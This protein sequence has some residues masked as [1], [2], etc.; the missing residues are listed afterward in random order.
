MA[1]TIIH[2][3]SSVAGKIPATTDLEYGELAINTSDAKVFLKDASNNIKAINSWAGIHDKPTGLTDAATAATPSTLVL[4]DSFGNFSAST[5]TADL[6]GN[7][8]GNAGTATKLETSRL[9]AGKTFDG[10]QDVTL[11]TLTRGTYLTGSNFNGS[12]ATTWAVDAT[13][14]NTAS[15]VVARDASGNFSAGTITANLSGNVTGSASNNVLKSGDTMTGF[16]T[17]HANPTNALHAATKQYV[18]NLEQGLKAKPAAKA[19]TSANIS[20]TYNNGSAGT[21][22]TLTIAPTATLSI[23]GVSTWAL[24]D[25][26][27]VKDQTNAAQNGRYYVS[28]IGS[29]SVAWVLTR[30]P[31]CDTADEIPGA[32]NFITDGT[33]KGT[34]W[35]QTVANP[36]TFVV[37]TDPITVIQF[38]GA[39]E[40]T[41]GTGITVSGNEIALSNAPASTNTANTLV[42]RDSSG[43]FSAGTIT[44]ALTGNASTASKWAT[45]RTITLNGDLTG[46]VSIDGSANVTLTATVA[47]NSVA[48]GTDTTG[49]YVADVTAGS[50]ITKTGTAGEGWSPTIAVDATTTNTANKVVARDASGNFAAGTITA[51]LSGNAST[52][53]TLQTARTINGT[54]FNGSAN[55]TTANWG[56]SRTLTI[57]STGKSVNGSGNVSWSL[58][59]IGAAAT[60]HTHAYL[61][62]T[63]GTLIG[64]M[65]APSSRFVG[66]GNGY[67]AGGIMV[68]GGGSGNTV[69]PSIG[70]HQPGLYGATLQCRAGDT[71]GF[72]DI[73]GVN[74]I[75][76]HAANFIGIAA[77]ARYADLAENYVADA[78]Y[79]PGTV[80]EFG[81]DQEVTLAIEAGSHR[82]AGVVSTNPAY[83]MNSECE[84]EHVVAI[85]LQGRVPCK[86]QGTVR[87]G[88]LLVSAGNGTARAWDFRAGS[89]P[90]T[91][92]V[93][94]KALANFTPAPGEQGIIEVVVGRD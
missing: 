86:V 1:N 79:E 27:L 42:L 36:S 78:A 64:G 12:A 88:D 17:L 32:Y 5:I 20:A 90:R 83:L 62:L 26:V 57:G 35:V 77:A 14:A 81:G 54:N 70:F 22:A 15:K 24:Q 50:Y 67:S 21:G 10:S 87:K 2:K 51:S 16:L 47:A 30:C 60:S 58:A 44:A 76:V 38:A 65:R 3:R 59:E 73:D 11:S 92:S 63:G 33:F 25:G 37:G 23:G 84:A 18:D 40:Y 61:P 41:G 75:N 89:N 72:Y 4:R 49:D 69:F 6:T 68:D 94:G 52:A 80:L 46:N 43:N 7:V 29:A 82:V 74:L 9:I 56:T 55:I 91:G 85:A 8:T 39:G 66:S 45:A 28:Q 34:G 71:F 93:I 13:S 31:Y 19:A 53:T 48:L